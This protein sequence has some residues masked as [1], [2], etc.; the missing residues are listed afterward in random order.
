MD[1]KSG[2]TWLQ[3][4]RQLHL[5][6]TQGLATGKR[7][8]SWWHGVIVVRGKIKIS[9]L[10]AF[11]NISFWWRVSVPL[12]RSSPSQDTHIW[13]PTGTSHK[14]KSLCERSKIYTLLTNMSICL[15]S[16]RS[17]ANRLLHWWTENSSAWRTFQNC[18]MF[19][20]RVNSSA[21]RTFQNCYTCL[22]TM[23]I[24][25]PEGPSRTVTFV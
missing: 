24:L 12:S 25:Q 10:F 6:K 11:G 22:T 4:N 14:L 9:L 23:L 20:N 2:E 21:W 18:Y 15:H 16:H 13:T 17:E 7:R 5:W 3:R 1:W 8:A 19:N